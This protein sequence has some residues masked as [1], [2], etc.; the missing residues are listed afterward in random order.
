MPAGYPGAVWLE[1]PNFTSGRTEAVTYV[2]M[3][4]TEGGLTSS[5]DTLT[6]PYKVNADGE[7]SRV[8]AHYVV[9]DDVIYQLVDDTDTAW[10]SRGFNPSSINIEVV[11]YADN[12]GTWSDKTVA[13]V[14]RLVAWLSSTYGIPLTYRADPEDPQPARGFMSHSSIQSNKRDPG[15]Y[16][17][18]EEI[19]AQAEGAPAGDLNT[20]IIGAIALVLIAIGLAVFR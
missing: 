6:D 12:P 5:L 1:S 14:S 3:H 17:P 20:E 9:S 18:W 4:T 7:P 2:I 15:P 16:F 10:T 13:N 19:K 11:G 8:S